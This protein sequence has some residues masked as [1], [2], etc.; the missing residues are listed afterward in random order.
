MV[1]LMMNYPNGVCLRQMGLRGMTIYMMA[2]ISVKIEQLRHEKA[3]L[4]YM[5]IQG[6]S[7]SPH[8]MITLYPCLLIANMI[9]ETRYTE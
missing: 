2:S 4:T 5:T 6:Q 1:V 8:I 3:A 9:T 7:S